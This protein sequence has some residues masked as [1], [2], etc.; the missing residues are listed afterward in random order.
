M[1][2]YNFESE[3]GEILT[4]FFKMSEVPKEIERSGKLYKRKYSCPNISYGKGY[5]PPT[6]SE[7][8][9]KMMTKENERAGERGREY[10][11]SK[12]PKLVQ[13]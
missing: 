5:L 11:R 9:R 1:P 10:W 12:K 13:Q 7:R 2:F 4:E 8:R 6:E 3:E